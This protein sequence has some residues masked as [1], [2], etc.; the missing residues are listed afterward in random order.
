MPKI[1][2]DYSQTII[3]K[4][5]CKDTNIKDIYIGHTTNFTQRKSHHKSGCYN[6]DGEQYNKSL[7]KCIRDNGG[8]DNWSMI[9]I[10]QVECNDKR[11]AE[12]LEHKWVELLS[13]SLNINKPYAMSTEDPVNYKH[14]WYETNKPA[15]LEKAKNNYEANKDQKLAYQKQYAEDHK[16]VIKDY[17]TDYR[18]MN[19][20]K[21]A[22]DKKVYREN[23][24]EKAAAANKEWREKNKE[25]IK[26]KNSQVLTCEGCGEQ[27][28]FGN[29]DRHMRS[30]KHLGE[31]TILK[32]ED[33]IQQENIEKLAKLRASQKAYREKNAEKI[34]AFKSKY[35]QENKEEKCK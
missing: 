34:K 20:E 25:Q 33:E 23:N 35:N 3:Y 14:N 12:A 6:E 18:D 16:D 15:I 7:Y 11:E 4:F 30:K 19:K 2:A 27:Y 32:T 1:P 8:W 31:S 29:K 21:L 13:P 5:C 10:E 26:E 28:T 17:Q 24:K 9:Q 22:A